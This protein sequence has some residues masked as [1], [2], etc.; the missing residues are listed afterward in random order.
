MIAIAPT[1]AI[2]FR[3]VYLEGTW[4][5]TTNVKRELSGV[6]FEQATKKIGSHNTLAALAFHLHYYIAGVTQVLQGGSLDIR[7]KY[8]FDMPP[9]ASQAD[10]EAMLAKH[11]EAGELFASLV[12]KLTDEQLAAPFFD[13][14]YGTYY[15]NMQVIVEH[16]YYHL[17]QIVLL[18][19]LFDS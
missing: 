1:L 15:R 5:V 16:T 13:P 9:L 14:K 8:S 2:Q 6:S 7:D 3:E 18:K 12:E 4:V 19:K 11:W 17:G 10:W